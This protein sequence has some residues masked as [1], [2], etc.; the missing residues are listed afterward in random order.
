MWGP[1]D[2]K[3]YEAEP[4]NLERAARCP[5]CDGVIGMKTWLPPY[6]CELELHG[7]ALGDFVRGPGDQVLISEKMAEA[8]QAEGL[9]GLLGFHPVEISRVLKRRRRMEPG[10]M[11]RYLVVAPCFGRGAV[12]EAHSLLRRKEPMTCPECRYTGMDSI[13]GFVLEPGT[14]Q[15]EDVFRPRGIPGCIVVS[16]RFAQ[17]VQ[18]HGFTNIKLIPTEDYIWDPLHLGPPTSAQSPPTSEDP[19]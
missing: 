9:T 1:H 8:F 13:N 5:R 10:A 11:P 7:Q 18:R 12:D 15:G 6:R 4:V 2:T 3:F 17:F 16:E 19:R 14:W